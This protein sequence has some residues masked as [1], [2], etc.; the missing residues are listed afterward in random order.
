[1][2]YSGVDAVVSIIAMNNI[3]AMRQD[4]DLFDSYKK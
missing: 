1:M 2:G 4:K 3:V